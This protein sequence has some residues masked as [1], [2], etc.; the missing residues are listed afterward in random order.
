MLMHHDYM[1]IV[2]GQETVVY[3]GTSGWLAISI[4]AA[5]SGVFTYV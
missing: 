4:L 2:F 5:Q 3:G 1:V